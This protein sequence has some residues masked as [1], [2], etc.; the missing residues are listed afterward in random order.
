MSSLVAEKT[1]YPARKLQ[2]KI[3]KNIPNE[4]IHENY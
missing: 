2:K 4:F 1:E 3:H